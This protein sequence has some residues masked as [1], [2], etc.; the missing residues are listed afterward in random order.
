MLE[1]GRII[2]AADALMD[3]RTLE[4]TKDHLLP[5]NIFSMMAAP[6][7]RGGKPAGIICCESVG[8]KREWTAE[9]EEFVSAVADLSVL[10]L[11]R[12]DREKA[13]TALQEQN[14]IFFKINE[15][16]FELASL[17][18]EVQIQPVLIKW[19][20]EITGAA[21]AWFSDYDPERKTLVV[22]EF[23]ARSGFFQSIIKALGRFPQEFNA[24]IDEKA[25]TRM[26]GTA[27]YRLKSLNELNA[28][29]WHMSTE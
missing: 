19:L 11:E 3:S 4:F 13:E 14:G 28:T 1:S 2:S 25:Y 17:P 7:M 9:E 6:L 5:H 22:R 10:S 26:T 21:A 20:F 27:I 16:A 29:A 15:L 18:N 24:P 23:E 8:E 12:H